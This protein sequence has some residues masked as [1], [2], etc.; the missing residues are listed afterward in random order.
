MK[1]TPTPETTPKSELEM[2]MDGTNMTVSFKTTEP[3]QKAQT[4]RVK[5]RKIPICDMDELGKGFGNFKKEVAVYCN[6]AIE[7]VERLDDESFSAVMSEGRR[8]NFTSFQKWFQ[9]QQD[10][11]AAMGQGS[12]LEPILKATLAK[13]LPE[14]KSV[15]P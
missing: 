3:D 15:R 9:W 2:L 11:L 8:L 7:W 4:E 14:E 10:T 6:K 1:E 5:V 12:A 13:L